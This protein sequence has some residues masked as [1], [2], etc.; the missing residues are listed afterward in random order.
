[1]AC[2][3]HVL[4]VLT[5]P[6]FPSSLRSSPPHAATTTERAVCPSWVFRCREQQ[7]LSSV[8]PSLSFLSPPRSN[9]CTTALPPLI[10]QC[11]SPANFLNKQVCLL[12]LNTHIHTGHPSLDLL[13]NNTLP[14]S[15]TNT[16]NDAVLISAP[17]SRWK[18][19]GTAS[20]CVG[21]NSC[22]QKCSFSSFSLQKW[23]CRCEPG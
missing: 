16:L 9:F 13:M 3:C 12:L 6:P 20:L 11:K 17:W 19:T 14:E 18:P 21:P 7:L 8:S 4:V 15:L 10:H 5:L 22:W 2:L 1:M 23:K